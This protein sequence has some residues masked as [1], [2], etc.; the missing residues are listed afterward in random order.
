MNALT[1]IAYTRA[2]RAQRELLPR[3]RAILCISAHWYTRGTGVTAMPW[4]RTIHDFGGFPQALFEVRYP[5]PGDPALAQE[6]QRLLQPLE[7]VADEAWG[8]DHG[9]W[10]VLV[11]LYPQADVPV[12]QLSIDATRPA[13]FH[14]E[15]GQR[16]APLRERGVLI[17]G[18][19]NIVH[20][21]RT[22]VR[23][24]Q[25]PVQDWAA[26]FGAQVREALLG[27]DHAA[28]IDYPRFGADSALAV[29]TPDHYLPMLYVLGTQGHAD[30]VRIFTEGFQYGSLDMTSFAV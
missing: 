25:A 5:A 8:L 18:S 23:Q 28:L 4:P 27:R 26:R 1:D 21:L 30:K 24:E 13:A 15:L 2:L 3:P 20:N 19:G 22:I 16:L 14:Y 7:V 17:L 10:Q 9:T 12:V 29:P 6:I 11:H